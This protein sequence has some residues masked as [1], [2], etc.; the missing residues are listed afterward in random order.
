[1]FCQ[2]QNNVLSAFKKIFVEETGV[3]L[4]KGEENE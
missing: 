2:N 4:R 1:M 3:N